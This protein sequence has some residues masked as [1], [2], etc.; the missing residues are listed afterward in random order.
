M[1]KGIIIVIVLTLLIVFITNVTI[2]IIEVN[3]VRSVKI[4]PSFSYSVKIKMIPLILLLGYIIIGN[5]DLI[6]SDL[7]E[8]HDY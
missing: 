7:I 2:L 3:F 4:T 8:Y 1:I 6:E 5:T